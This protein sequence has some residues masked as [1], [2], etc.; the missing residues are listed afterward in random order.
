MIFFQMTN[1]PAYFKSLARFTR[2]SAIEVYICCSFTGY[3]T[4]E[5]LE[6][7]K[8][9]PPPNQQVFVGSFLNPG[10]PPSALFAYFRR[11]PLIKTGYLDSQLFP[12]IPDQAECLSS[13]IPVYYLGQNHYQAGFNR[14]LTP[15]KDFVNPYGS[16]ESVTL[17]TLKTGCPPETT[18]PL[19]LAR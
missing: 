7:V 14:F 5:A 19:N 17:Y 18:L 1:P 11:D 3:P 4:R 13:D 15:V 12:P 2:N 9:L 16:E 6:Y 10:N 8:T